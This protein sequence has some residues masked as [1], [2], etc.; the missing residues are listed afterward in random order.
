MAELILDKEER[1]ALRAQAH[2]LNPVV[3][4][5]S[6][7]LTEPVYAEIDRALNAH[8]LIKVRIPSDDRDERESIWAAVADRLAAAR[9]QAIGKL[10]V[11]Y[12]PVPEQP[13]DE[14]K[15]RAK[16]AK[17]GKAKANFKRAPAPARRRTHR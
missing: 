2:A 14:D 5:G 10:V 12:R 17:R 11:L 3:L 9:V 16:P 8:G 13:A 4:M 15:P 6:A 7:G 1:L